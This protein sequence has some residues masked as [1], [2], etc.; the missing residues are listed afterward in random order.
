VGEVKS[1]A[2]RITRWWRG[3][4]AAFRFRKIRRFRAW[5]ETAAL[6]NKARKDEKELEPEADLSLDLMDFTPEEVKQYQ[7]ISAGEDLTPTAEYLDSLHR[8]TDDGRRLNSL[9]RYSEDYWTINLMN[10]GKSRVFKRILP[11][12]RANLLVS[13]IVATFY[14]KY[15][16]MPTL[17]GPVHT[18]TGSFMGL[19]IAFRTNTGYE[20]FWEARKVWEQIQNRCRNMARIIANYVVGDDQMV[21]RVMQILTAYPYALKQHL[22]GQRNLEEMRRV[23][24]DRDVALLEESSNMPQTLCMMLS[25][26]IR[27]LLVNSAGQIENQYL[28]ET[29]DRHIQEL[30][31]HIGASERLATTPVPLSYSRHTSR[32]LSIW[33]LTFPFFMASYCHP[34]ISVF[35]YGFVCWA[36]FGTEEVGHIIEEPFGIPRSKKKA[37]ANGSKQDKEEHNTENLPLLRYCEAI[38][39]DIEELQGQYSLLPTTAPQC[40]ISYTTI[41][42]D[43]EEEMFIANGDQDKW[44]QSRDPSS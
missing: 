23:L 8:F 31:S 19:L 18:I 38:K 40:T 6:S 43:N 28:W 17:T 9:S 39:Y 25:L 35:A 21:L 2:G 27:K 20:R 1:K 32:F 22:R 11:H 15:P 36:L 16:G 42:V 14:Y 30:V 5:M 44:G 4:F 34:Y 33:T 41:V 24:G 10:L 26:T 37:D 12:L 13:A 29:L 3:F 7:E